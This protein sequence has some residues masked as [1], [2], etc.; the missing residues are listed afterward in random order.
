MLLFGAL[1]ALFSDALRQ[2]SVLTDPY[3]WHALIFA[4][5]FN[6]AVFYALHLFPDWMWMYF[7]DD[8]SNTRH[9]LIYLFVFLYYLPVIFGYYLG[10]DLKRVSLFFWFLFI[11]FLALAEAWLIWHLYDR[12]SVIGTN[13]EFASGTAISLFGPQN[14]MS[15]VMNG[16]IGGMVVYF[17]FVI[18][19]YKKRPRRMF[20]K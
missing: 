16:S 5:I 17:I 4:S 3:L 19:L 1:F 7:R 11:L 2:H 8:S 13:Q 18:V 20:H 14:P 15:T 10:R 12:Y 6:I 9:E